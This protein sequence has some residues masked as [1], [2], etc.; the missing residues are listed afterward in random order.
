[1]DTAKE[2]LLSYPNGRKGSITIPGNV[3]EIAPNAIYKVPDADAVYINAAD[4]DYETVVTLNEGAVVHATG[5]DMLYFIKDATEEALL[6]TKYQNDTDNNWSG[7][8]LDRYFELEVSEKSKDGDGNYWATMY[9][10]WDT[11]LPD[12]LTPYIVDSEKTNEESSTLV[13]RE[14]SR[15]LPKR[16]PVVIRANQAG[17]YKL[18]PT[19]GDPYGELPMSENLLEGVNKY[20]MDV[21][22]SDSNDG[23]CLTLGKNSNGEVGFF[24]YKGTAKIPAFRSYLTVNKVGAEARVLTIVQDS[25][26][27]TTVKATSGPQDS[28]DP[29]FFDL[30]GQR[31]EHPSKGLFINNGR[32]TVRK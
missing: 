24:I 21:Y 7:K 25:D 17:K 2:K 3:T 29:I 1:M 9:I 8:T 26:Q 19:K 28:G 6:F 32:V 20:G 11:D 12:A 16:T 18:Y 31:T 4:Y 13:L 14:I 27:T 23:G 15:K 22:Q 30:K 10:G 5:K